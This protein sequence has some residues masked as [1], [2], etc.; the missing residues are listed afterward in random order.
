MGHIEGRIILRD[1]K[2]VKSFSLQCIDDVLPVV[3]ETAWANYGKK[4]A[5]YLQLHD[6]GELEIKPE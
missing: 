2:F 1:G 3:F 5:L 4:L 6:N